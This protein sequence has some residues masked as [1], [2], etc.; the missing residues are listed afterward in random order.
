MALVA[1]MPLN[2]HLRWNFEYLD[3]SQG[4][5]VWSD[6]GEEHQQAKSQNRH[7]LKYVHIEALNICTGAI[8]RV[9]S[10]DAAEYEDFRF[11]FVGYMQPMHQNHKQVVST[12]V[13]G[14]QIVSRRYIHSVDIMGNS[15]STAREILCQ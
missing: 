8:H 9:F 12:Y 6:P 10:V 13:I 3:G 11:K 4:H 2:Y 7:G 15:S 14:A 1:G 5:G